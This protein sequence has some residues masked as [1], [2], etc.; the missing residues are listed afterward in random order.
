MASSKKM[1]ESYYFDTSVPIPTE[2]LLELI[3][4]SCTG[5]EECH[6]TF[7]KP[8]ETLTHHQLYEKAMD[9]AKGLLEIGLKRGD[10]FC[11]FGSQ[12]S[13][14]V[15]LLVAC[16][17]LGLKYTANYLY[18]PISKVMTM[19]IKKIK[20]TAVLIGNCTSGKYQEHVCTE[21]TKVISEMA[22]GEGHG[23]SHIFYD[24]HAAADPQVLH[25]QVHN[26]LKDVEITLGT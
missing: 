26:I 11:S 8:Y 15:L 16:L 12:G 5:N 3:R 14:S 20:P 2:S 7:T 6:V 25:T 10:S 4:N 23:I 18:S 22:A 9:L 13:D 24:K 1:C 19:M 17:S 21:F